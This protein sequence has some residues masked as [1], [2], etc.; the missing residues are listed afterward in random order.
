MTLPKSE[1]W[2]YVVAILW[3]C[4]SQRIGFSP[5]LFWRNFFHNFFFYKFFTNL[6]SCISR[7]DLDGFVNA[8]QIFWIATVLYNR[9]ANAE[10]WDYKDW[11]SVTWGRQ[12]ALVTCVKGCHNTRHLWQRL[13]QHSSLVASPLVTR[14]VTAF[15][16]RDSCCDSL[17][18]SW[19]VLLTA[20][21]DRFF[22]PCNPKSR[23]CYN[24]LKPNSQD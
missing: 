24:P 18:H 13:S 14:V 4:Q 2:F 12:Q 10:T 7:I 16:T 17:W 21:R 22:N 1:D 5:T 11:K 3:L 19:L 8:T 6:F 9:N 23:H 20:S 15:D